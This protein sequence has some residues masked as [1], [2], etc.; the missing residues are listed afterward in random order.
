MIGEIDR[1][2][3]SIDNT[4]WILIVLKWEQYSWQGLKINPARN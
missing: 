2:Y 3:P 1:K 4:E